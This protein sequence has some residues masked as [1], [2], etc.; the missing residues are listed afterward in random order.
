MKVYELSRKLGTDNKTLITFFKDNDF[1]VASHNQNL[2]DEQVAFAKKNFDAKKYQEP[3]VEI[4]DELEEDIK[5]YRVTIAHT[6]ALEI[7]E[8]FGQMMK[9]QFGDDRLLDILRHTKFDSAQHVIEHLGEAVEEHRKGAEPN[10]D[11]TM[12]CLRIN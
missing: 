12:L 6:D 8:Q 1:K 2:T 4:D 3:K 7:A 5:N 10:D 11:L 9:A